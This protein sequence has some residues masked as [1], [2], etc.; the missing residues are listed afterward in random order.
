MSW[1]ALRLTSRSP[2]E[3]LAVLGP[4]GVEELIREARN[5]CWRDCPQEQ[6]TP[7]T[8]QQDLRQVFDRNIKTWSAIKKPSPEAFFQDLLPHAADGHM[9]QALV[10]CWMMLPRGVRSLAAVHDVFTRIFERT[11]QAW[12]EDNQTFTKGPARRKASKKKSA[13]ETK[14]GKRKSSRR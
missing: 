3:L 10:L 9:R 11:M 1:E 6:R 12:D 8:V 2:A 7:A 5:A 14:T 13:P 4:H